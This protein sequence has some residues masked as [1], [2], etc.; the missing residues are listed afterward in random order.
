MGATEREITAAEKLLGVHILGGYRSFLKDFGWGG[1]ECLELYGLG[2]D[3]PR[4]LNLS[5][6]TQS[7]RQKMN[8]PLQA[9][10]IPL[11]N[12]GGGNLYCINTQTEGEPKVV[13]WDHENSKDQLPEFEAITFA[14]WLNAELDTIEPPPE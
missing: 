6:I 14:A 4:H 5:E 3:V 13:F 1:V 2:R 7:E 8:P 10:L 9:H 12:D 11:M